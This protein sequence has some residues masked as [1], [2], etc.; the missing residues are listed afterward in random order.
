MGINGKEDAA[1]N[2]ARGHYTIGKEIVDLVLDRIRKLADQCSGLQ[3]FLLFHSFGGGT[4]SGFSSLLMERLSLDYGKKSKLEFAIY[5]APQ[6]STAVVEP[7]NSILTTH[8]TLE[9]SDC[10]FMVDNEAIYD[11]CRRNLDIDRPTYTNLNRTWGQIVSS[12]TASLRFDG[13]LNVDLTEFQTNLVPYPRI[14]FPLV[15]YAPVISA[16]KAYHEQLS[17]A[18]ITNACFEPANQMVKCDPRHGKYMACCLLYR[19]DVVPKDV[20]AAIATIK[21]KRTIQFVDWCP[22]GFKVGINYQPPTVVPG[23]DLAKVQ[24][25]VCMLSNTTAMAEVAPEIKAI[26]EKPIIIEIIQ[27]EIRNAK[28]SG[29]EP[30]WSVNMKKA[31]ALLFQ[32]KIDSASWLPTEENQIVTSYSDNFWKTKEQ[33]ID[34]ICEVT[35][36]INELPHYMVHDRPELVP[37]PELCEGK[38]FFEVIKT[39]NVDNCDRVASFYSYKPGHFQ[40][41]AITRTSHTHVLAC[42]T[43]GNMVIQTIINQGELNQD[44]LQLN[45]ERI[46]SGNLQTL[47]LK[48][49]KTVAPVPAPSD[50]KVLKN[51]MYEYTYK[52]YEQDQVMEVSEEIPSRIPSEVLHE[53]EELAKILPRSMLQG[54]KSPL[55]AATIKTEVKT[56]MKSI[57]TEMSSPQT[58]NLSEKQVTMKLLSVA[59]GLGMM[60][61][62]DI[63]SLYQS[64]KSEFSSDEVS[65]ATVKKLFY[66][67]V[68]MAGTPEAIRFLKEQ[69]L[70]NDMTKLEIVILLH[71]LPNNILIPSEQVLEELLDLVKSTKFQESRLLRN[72]ATMSF[73]TVLEKACL[74][75]DREFTFPS[76]VMGKLCTPE[77]PILLKKWVPYLLAQLESAQTWEI[78]NEIIVALG[79]LPRQEILG[80]LLPFLEGRIGQQ[81]VPVMTRLLALW[82]ISNFH[83]QPELIE[84]ILFALYSNP[85]ESSEIRISAFN[86]LL[87]LNPS[88]PVFHKIAARTWSE[89]DVEVLRAINTAFVTLMRTETITAMATD[90]HYMSLAKKAKLTYPLIKKTP[91]GF[92]FVS[93]SLYA[94]D[95]LP[96]LESRYQMLGAWIADSKS[97][98]TK[99][100]WIQIDYFLSQYR[101]NAVSAGLR[102]EGMENIYNHLTELLTPLNSGESVQQ[103]QESIVKMI[104]ENMHSEWRKVMQKLNIKTRESDKVSVAAYL[105]I[106][107]ATPLF[108]NIFEETVQSLK[109]KINNIFTNPRAFIKSELNGKEHRLIAKHAM[110]LSP[111]M[112][113]IPTDMGL[114]LEMELHMPVVASLDT[115]LSVMAALP[116]PEFRMDTR[117]FLSTQITGWV[118]TVIPFTKEVALVALDNTVVYNLPASIKINIDMPKQHLK[119]SVSL[120]KQLNKATDLV[121]HHAHPFSVIQ[122]VEDFTPITLSANMKII[123][124]GEQLKKVERTFGESLGLHLHVYRRTESRYVDLQ[125]IIERAA[126]FN[127]NPLTLLMFPTDMALNPAG[128]LSLRRNEHC[129][130]IDPTQSTT[131]ALSVDFVFGYASKI[132]D[133]QAVK[134]HKLKILSAPEQEQRVEQEPNLILKQLKKLWLSPKNNPLVCN[135]FKPSIFSPARLLLP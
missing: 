87:K 81:E 133:V 77:S 117:L 1:N 26:L 62:S 112:A 55:P 49:I 23:G 131:K 106:L 21:T 37:R 82:S 121:H 9:H 15:T 56:L 45:T 24:R 54:Q 130:R 103:Q 27:G 22:T 118:G 36:Q 16:E 135:G 42:G 108:G 134:Y 57:V 71:Q 79:M 72:I 96:R 99:D 88:M 12:I 80:K 129:L 4:G 29:A 68:L 20:N 18:E 47:R 94:S 51:M 38:K 53:P 78:K 109:E 74:A 17:V 39:K 83:S 31:L 89:Q 111:V 64:L 128:T 52:S 10:A 66:D 63:L 7:Y 124:S 61:K 92:A 123:E 60:K 8:T 41:M 3:G 65:K 35:Y 84:P 102:M 125:S 48:E 6:V 104:Q 73:T 100:V 93:A 25:A 95:L 105:R 91:L 97:F 75:K 116:K 19:G 2:Y 30:E 14:H 127:Y 98:L 113:L 70:K 69:I 46:V 107:E 40:T 44:L 59:R 67:V 76:W 132:K 32:T 50:L 5:P 11:I 33:G 85:A 34:G 86:A 120:D 90:I 101:L 114:P 13:A 58:M 126:I 119:M 122:K 115:K 110:D 43:R 28:I